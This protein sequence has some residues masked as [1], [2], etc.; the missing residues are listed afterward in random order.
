VAAGYKSSGS[1]VGRTQQE[2]N[3]SLQKYVSHE[4]ASMLKETA[5]V[6]TGHSA[7]QLSKSVRK[8]LESHLAV[9]KQAQ[10]G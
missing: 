5:L 1:P 10:P 8:W 4:Q 3:N 7:K 2:R 9:L 6:M